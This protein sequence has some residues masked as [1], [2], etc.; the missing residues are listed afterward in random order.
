M[1]SFQ[2]IHLLTFWLW[3]V[4]IWLLDY[5]QKQGNIGIRAVCGVCWATKAE[6]LTGR[7]VPVKL[8]TSMNKGR[9]VKGLWR[10]K[11]DETITAVFC[12]YA[13]WFP[14]VAVPHKPGRTQPFFFIA[15]LNLSI[16]SH[17]TTLDSDKWGQ[18]YFSDPAWCP[19]QINNL[20]QVQI[21]SILLPSE[22]CV[23]LCLSRLQRSSMLLFLG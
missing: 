1:L 7:L 8:H 13:S 15:Y 4:R 3:L 22:F 19:H 5:T 21:V 6:L 9:L 14:Q 17:H 18:S 12:L 10:G 23:L 2:G 11:Y 20:Y 16:F